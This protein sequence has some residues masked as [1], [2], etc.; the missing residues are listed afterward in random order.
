MPKILGISMERTMVF[1]GS[2]VNKEPACSAEE[3]ASIPG[4][5][6]SPGKGNGNHSRILA[7]EIP[8]TEEPS[9]LQFMAS[10]RLGDDWAAVT[11]YGKND[12]LIYLKASS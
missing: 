4:S 11:N 2:S 3:P 8:W 12:S 9:G 5:G 6:R 10:Q 1:P 7:W